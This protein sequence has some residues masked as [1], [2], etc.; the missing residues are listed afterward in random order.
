MLGPQKQTLP[1]NR[2]DV[3][4]DDGAEFVDPVRVIV[5]LFREA[6]DVAA[7]DRDHAQSL[8]A[9]HTPIWGLGFQ[10]EHRGVL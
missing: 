1:S 8:E 5:P 3:A 6:D 10:A 9:L 4:T 2:D 7:V